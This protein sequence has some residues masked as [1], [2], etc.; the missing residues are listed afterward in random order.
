MAAAWRRGALSRRDR[1]GPATR[2]PRRGAGRR[3]R[4]AGDGRGG[5][6][7]PGDPRLPRA[8]GG[9]SAVD[10]RGAARL[11]GRRR[12][13]GDVGRRRAGAAGPR[14]ARSAAIARRR[15]RL[16]RGGG[17]VSRDAPPGD[18]RTRHARRRGQRAL[19]PGA[20]RGLRRGAPRRAR[21]PVDRRPRR[22]P[23]RARERHGDARAAHGP[24]GVAAHC[25]PRAPAQLARRARGL[26]DQRPA[27]HRP[28]DHGRRGRERPRGVARGGGRPR[29]RGDCCRFDGAARGADHASLGSRRGPARPARH[30]RGRR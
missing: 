7:R 15:G 14:H 10:Q 4:V 18:R 19:P 1:H 11:S 2:P 8:L 6:H 30:R 21:R 20:G 13:P 28:A 12:R 17:R 23:G 29:R 26:G 25:A 24:A 9:I 16:R 22:R 5:R 3:D 27:R